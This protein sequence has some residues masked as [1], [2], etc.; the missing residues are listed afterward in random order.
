MPV[1][2]ICITLFCSVLGCDYVLHSTAQ[3]YS[4]KRKHER[5]DFESAYKKYRD[6]TVAKPI[7]PRSDF[8][9]IQQVASLTG[10]PII[11][12]L[13]G[14]LN[15]QAGLKRQ[16]E[17][18]PS[19]PLELK[20][21]K[22]EP[23]SDVESVTASNQSSRSTPTEKLNIKPD[24]DAMDVEASSDLDDSIDEM[25]EEHKNLRRTFGDEEGLKLSGSLTLPIPMFKGQGK[26][27]E[28]NSATSPV[29]S[30]TFTQPQSLS[31]SPLEKLQN[32]GPVFTTMPSLNASMPST[33][34]TMNPGA[35]LNVSSTF[36]GPATVLQ[37]PKSVYTERREKDDSWKTYLVRYVFN[38]F[39]YNKEM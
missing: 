15:L 33:L 30:P 13:P 17:W 10:S 14:V 39:H 23:T 25:H 11:S 36:P 27:N 4:H 38:S 34:V 1:I 21:P 31:M 29:T 12:T 8:G 7:L 16:M 5:R 32:S 6:K 37:P 2:L 9:N 20:K 18:E 28:S 19:E 3:L 24:P 22:L 26:R 35:L